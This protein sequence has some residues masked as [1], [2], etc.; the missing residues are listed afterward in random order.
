MSNINKDTIINLLQDNFYDNCIKRKLD[1]VNTM[2]TFTFSTILTFS[3]INVI[4]CFNDL[5]GTEL[6]FIIYLMFCF[7]NIHNLTSKAKNELRSDYL[8]YRNSLDVC[9]SYTYKHKYE[10][11]KTLEIINSNSNKSFQDY[12]KLIVSL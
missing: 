1:Y 3:I 6:I 12:V 4:A 8:C 5:Y 11:L 2:K 7:Y 9:S 10:L